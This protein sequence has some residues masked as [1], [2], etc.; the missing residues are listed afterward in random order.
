[1]ARRTSAE[2]DFALFRT[3]FDEEEKLRKEQ[4]RIEER[5]RK[6]RGRSGL[7]SIL[8]T[9]IG[10]LLTGGGSAIATGLG[11]GIGSRFGSEVGE[12]ST[13]GSSQ[14]G[15]DFLFNQPQIRQQNFE[16][17]QQDREF[18]SGQNIDALMKAVTA[19]FAAPEIAGMKGKLFGRGALPSGLAAG[20]RSLGS[21]GGF[22]TPQRRPQTPLDFTGIDLESLL[23]LLMRR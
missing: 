1:M 17:R 23:R 11:A 4:N 14:I 3:I 19:G 5:E 21:R 8:G 9:I 10:A 22:I 6:K 16:Q 2:A 12:R 15:G 7:G 13:R 20:Q 18:G